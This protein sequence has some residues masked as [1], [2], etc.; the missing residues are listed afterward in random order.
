MQGDTDKILLIP[1][2]KKDFGVDFLLNAGEKRDRKPWFDI[3]KRYQTDFFEFFYFHKV[4]GFAYIAGKRIDL[5]DNTLLI[6]SPFQS[7]EW[8]VDIE[9][10]DYTFLLFHEEFIHNF[11]T[12]KCL[13]YKMLFCYQYEKPTA[14]HMPI[15][16][17]E[18]FHSIIRSIR[19]ELRN[20]ACGTYH[21]IVSYLQMFLI[22]LNRWYAKTFNIPQK[23]PSDNYAYFYKQLIENNI[24]TSYR[25]KDYASMLGISTVSLNRSVKE[26][27][28]V[29]AI[30]LL[31]KRLIQEIKSC[32]LFGKY[33]IKETAYKLNFSDISNL[34]RFFKR[35]TG[36]TLTEFLEEQQ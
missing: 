36:V 21:M 13:M 24:Y 20:P 30:Q 11:I 18:R 23:T 22:N 16:E 14:F 34:S 2:S 15:C 25:I 12:D 28:G 27:F 3:C 4:R 5:S 1:Y 35:Q 32:L 6:I 19:E 26:T 10:C 17:W 31:H 29:T 8:H 33:S 7:E 9:S